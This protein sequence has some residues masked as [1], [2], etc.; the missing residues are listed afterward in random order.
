MHRG[1]D[2]GRCL[3]LPIDPIQLDPSPA[4]A[5]ESSRDQHSRREGAGQSPGPALGGRLGLGFQGT[6]GLG[7][8]GQLGGTQPLLHSRQVAG[9]PAG[10]DSRV[11]RAVRGLGGQAFADQDDQLEVGLT[12]TEP[13]QRGGGIGPAGR[14][15]DFRQRVAA[16]RRRPSQDLAQ[17]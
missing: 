5:E 6:C 14:A 10:H 4:G 12:A 7:G 13:I 3:A 8:A 2:A 11:G 17:D 16:K 15:E 1:V 9:D